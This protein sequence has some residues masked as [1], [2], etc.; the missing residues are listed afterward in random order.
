L[1]LGHLVIHRP[2]FAR[3]E[4]LNALLH[5]YPD[6]HI[7]NVSAEEMQDMH[8]NVLSL[9]PGTVVSNRSATR[10]NKQ[11]RAWGYDVIEAELSETSKMGGLLRCATLPLRRN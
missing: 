7:M 8:C 1:G 5:R 6:T 11:M 10:T 3:D 9:E 2:G 4:E